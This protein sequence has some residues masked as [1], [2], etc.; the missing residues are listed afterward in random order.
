LDRWLDGFRTPPR[1][2][3]VTHGDADVAAKTAERIRKERS[4][5]VE[6]PEYR[7]IWDLD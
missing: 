2:L 3:F 5:T 4:W 1:R 6:L 7:E